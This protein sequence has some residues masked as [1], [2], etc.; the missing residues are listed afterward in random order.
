MSIARISIACISIAK[1]TAA[2]T[3]PRRPSLDRHLREFIR[4]SI[5]IIASIATLAAGMP[6]SGFA[7]DIIISG[8]MGNPASTDSPYE[9][10]QLIATKAID[11]STTNYSVVWNNNGTAT[12]S[13]WVAGG[14]LSYGFNLTAGS[15]NAGDVFYVGGSGR[16]INGVGTTD[17][18]SATW[19]RTIATGSVAGDGFGSAASGGPLGNGGANAD[20]IGVF[21]GLTSSLTASSTPIDAIFFGTGVGTAYNAGTG[22]GYRV[23]SNGNYT[24]GL[25]GSTGNTTLFADPGSGVF[26]KLTGTFNTTSGSWTSIRTSGSVANPTALSQIATGITLTSGGGAG[27]V[28]QNTTLSV[29]SGTTTDAN[30]YSGSTDANTAGSGSLIKT[31]VG[32]LVLTG[33]S[34]YTG[35]TQIHEG[36]VSVSTL[37]GTVSPLG[38]GGSIAIG[39]G[40]TA[41]TLSYTGS[42]ASSSRS[43][44]LGVG[45]ATLDVA[46]SNLTIS[47]GIGGTGGLTKSG[48]GTLTLT[49]NNTYTGN[50]VVSGGVLDLNGASSA[51]DDVASVTVQNNATFKTTG[52]SET[53]GSIVLT[54]GTIVTDGANQFRAGSYTVSQGA[55]NGILA[56][57]SG[58]AAP[59]TKTGAGTVTINAAQAY[60]GATNVNAGT[61]ALGA[62]GA[63]ATSPSINVASAA[64][65]DLSAVT[66]GITLGATQSLAGAGTV[67]GAV[68]ISGTV[69]PGDSGA[70]GTLTFAETTLNGGGVLNV[71]LFDASS[72]AGT[73][74]DL[75][76]TGAVTFANSSGSKFTINL[77]SVSTSGG[78]AGSATNFNNANDANFKI[79][80][81][82]SFST[83]FDASTFS[84][85][86]AGFSNAL[87]GGSWGVTSQGA[88]IYVSFTA[89]QSLTWVGGDGAWAATGGTAWSGGEWNSQKTASFA[90]TAGTVTVDAAGVSAGRGLDFGVTGY[91][92]TGGPIA[93]S[94]STASLNTVTVGSGSATVAS[95]LSGNNGLTKAGAGTLILAG[96]N[97]FTGGSQINV[98]TVQLGNGGTAG[99]LAGN[100]TIGSGATLAVNRSDALTLAGNLTGAGAVTKAGGG[101]LTLSGSNDY[102]G[103]TTVTGGAVAVDS[104]TRLGTGAVTL[105]GGRLTYSGGVETLASGSIGT[106]GGTF[107]IG[108]GGALTITTLSGTGNSLV[109]EGSGTLNVAALPATFLA[110]AGVLSTA[111]NG[112]YN[113]GTDLANAGTI[114]F[115][116]T[117]ATRVNIN[118]NQSG[119]GAFRFGATGQSIAVSGASGTASNPIVLAVASGTVNIGATSGFTLALNGVISGTGNV[120]F[121]VGTTGGAGV[122]VLGA[123]STF[124]G[125]VVVN[126]SASG[127]HRLG[128]TN[129]IPTTAGVTFGS[130]AGSIDLNGFN[131]QLAFLASANSGGIH[132]SAAGRATLTIDGTASTTYA[133]AIGTSGSANIALVKAGSGILTLSGS[134]AYT[135]GTTINGGALS[136]AADSALGAS[137]GGI[138]LG[139]GSLVATNDFT[140]ASS[141][142]ITASAS[143]TSGIDVVS[144]KTLT[145]GGA[146]TGSGNLDKR[147]PGTLTVSGSSPGYTGRFTVSSGTMNV[148]GTG[149]F[150]N[151]TL[152]QTGGK[153][154]FNSGIGG[155]GTI[156]ID[157]LEGD[158]GEIEVGAG[159][160]IAV[161]G[162]GQ[163]GTYGGRI[164]GNGGFEKKG[165][166]K[167]DL[168]KDN[169]YA[170]ATSISGGILEIRSG[171]KLSNTSGVTVGGGGMLQVN[172]EVGRSDKPAAVTVQ[173]GGVLGGSGSVFGTVGGSGQV[174]PGNS[175]GIFTST[176]TDPTSGLDY[177]FELTGTGSPV[178]SNSTASVNDVWRLTGASPFTSSSLTGANVIDIYF[179][180]GFAENN[181]YLGGFF[182]DA[183]AGSF[184]GF[185]NAVQVATY[186]FFVLDAGGTT[187]YLGNTYRTL[188]QW[189]AANSLGLSVQTSVTTVG[190]A[191]FTGGSVT[192]GQSMQFVIVPEPSA[193][194]L[195]GLGAALA[196]YAAWRRRTPA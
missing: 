175:P 102:S 23:P 62:S 24:G 106:G 32:T 58:T 113:V 39:T 53:L 2:N 192:N 16:L 108:S 99:S 159:D 44:S 167:L 141:R 60:T 84:L 187:S 35:S 48:A 154:V 96:D 52:D 66:G 5:A 75:L 139:G 111:Q 129:A 179:G 168:D 114:E 6:T 177:A 142:T 73:G 132:N 97:T 160:R 105:N 149:L 153:L 4:K 27:P 158:D 164:R 72:T 135:G 170:G 128:V 71:S 180:A 30:F 83:T 94:G 88:D 25:F 8:Y 33:S 47:T 133:R 176:A 12:T 151:A 82:S 92:V 116:G 172:G 121:A 110:N 49:G 22:A 171:G 98:G 43:L 104:V 169:D 122:T 80:S 196:C 144:G 42:D 118:S 163:S 1:N 194:A 74:W 55:I 165:S 11:F 91:T 69:N 15:V 131:Q 21:S 138:T 36:V 45:G 31:G 41:G 126:S 3:T 189:N 37:T 63:I 17:I 124:T 130:T 193:F 93:L 107:N 173:S 89:G 19:I 67:T 147:G 137:S 182:T 76:T 100:V 148:N 56:N 29:A 18:S 40:S 186:N 109:K 157:D 28:A 155:G 86:T 50:T 185:L 120:N 101:T 68:A 79:L 61:L 77:S 174:G 125:N 183:T 46:S 184:P 54:S 190:S 140:L 117:G 191:N 9:Y 87:G 123:A 150:A 152:Q 127:V 26:V 146:F 156:D 14:S 65:L 51:I 134:S 13:G 95:V 181:A 59:F 162:N 81:A 78:A 136:V 195:A 103:G 119:S 20:G 64:T 112:T 85:N 10:V 178:W 115:T 143:T 34:F 7:H 166:G 38:N 161:G 145:F 90:G 57:K 188:A 70:I